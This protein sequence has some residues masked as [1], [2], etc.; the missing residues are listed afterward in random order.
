MV[1]G[2]GT[3][4][5]NII[6]MLILVIQSMLKENFEC[7]VN[8]VDVITLHPLKMVHFFRMAAYVGNAGPD[9]CGEHVMVTAGDKYIS[10]TALQLPAPGA[11]SSTFGALSFAYYLINNYQV[12]LQGEI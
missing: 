5:Y 3:G 10:A 4:S 8:N 1:I 2:R 6:N 12:C 7:L 11:L 9:W